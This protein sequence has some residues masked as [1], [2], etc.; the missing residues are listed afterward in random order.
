MS[1]VGFWETVHRELIE[2]GVLPPD[3]PQPSNKYH[4]DVTEAVMNC[5]WKGGRW[6]CDPAA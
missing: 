1:K 5:S 3:S 4:Q 2:S 6:V